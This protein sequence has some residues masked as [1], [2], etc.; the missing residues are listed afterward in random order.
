MRIAVLSDI[1]LA[2]GS[3]NR[4]GVDPAKLAE[5]LE[6]TREQFDRVV[7]NG[8]IYDLSRPVL[9]FGWRAHLDA[10]EREFATLTSEFAQCDWTF[11]NHD[12]P[13]AELGASLDWTTRDG[14]AVYIHHGHVFDRGLKRLPIVEQG[15]N[16]AAGW[17]DRAGVPI[18]NRVLEGISDTSERVAAGE[19]P[20]VSGARTMLGRG[21]DLVVQGHSHRP[22]LERFDEGVY[23]NTGSQ[24]GDSIEWGWFDTESREVALMRDDDEVAALVV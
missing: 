3:T 5:F 6:G 22:F 18:L 20:D 16:F 13:L 1:H 9:P 4:M 7:L 14:L 15:A 12:R 10:I 19:T 24:L 23:L 11:G 17:F 8:D 21:W 2:P